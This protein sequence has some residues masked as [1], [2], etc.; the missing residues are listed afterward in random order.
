MARQN[1]FFFLFGPLLKQFAHHWC[2]WTFCRF[3]RAFF[4]LSVYAMSLWALPF[5][6]HSSICLKHCTVSQRRQ[7]KSQWTY[8][9]SWNFLRL[10]QV[11]RHL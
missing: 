7:H 8:K 9:V 1:F 5:P 10:V 4:F 2:R 11:F 6:Q 3:G